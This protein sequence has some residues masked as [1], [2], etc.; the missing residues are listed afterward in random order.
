[1]AA[2]N[3]HAEDVKLAVITSE[4]DQNVTEFYLETDDQNQIH[5]MRYITTMPNGGIAEDVSL[6][7]DKVLN[8]G[9]VIVERDGRQIVR[10]SVD[11]FSLETGGSFKLSYLYN[12]I[13]NSWQS[14]SLQVKLVGGQFSL[15]EMNNN[16]ANRLYVKKH[17]S[18]IFGVIGVKEIQTL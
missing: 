10:L 9:A 8:E 4:F 11:Y 2:V 17:H 5:S 12:G 6:T 18:K 1:M 14:K 7:A 3:V 16:K 13:T 15:L